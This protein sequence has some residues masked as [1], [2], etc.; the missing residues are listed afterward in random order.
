MSIDFDVKYQ[1]GHSCSESWEKS[2]YFCPGCGAKNTYVCISGEDYYAGPQY[3]CL[4]CK[5]DFY[6]GSGVYPADDLQN[7]Q[8][9]EALQATSHTPESPPPIPPDSPD[10]GV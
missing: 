9:I 1:A 4:S 8:R 5:C 3:L 2:D 7:R 10:S 6:L